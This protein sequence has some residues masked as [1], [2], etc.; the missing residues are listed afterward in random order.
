MVFMVSF[1]GV[2]LNADPCM[3]ESIDNLNPPFNDGV[4]D[5]RIWHGQ[6]AMD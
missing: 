1:P 6:V 3:T 5:F 2:T 4:L